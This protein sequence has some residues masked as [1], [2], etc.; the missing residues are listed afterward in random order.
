[1]TGI[2]NETE[3]TE[4]TMKKSG[5]EKNKLCGAC[6]EQAAHSMRG[7]GRWHQTECPSQNACVGDER[8]LERLDWIGGSPAPKTK[9]SG[10]SR[11]EKGW[12]R[13]AY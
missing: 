8:N 7:V 13:P 3:R 5:V 6:A 2:R 1:V 4:V 11:S 9:S 12:R 10:K